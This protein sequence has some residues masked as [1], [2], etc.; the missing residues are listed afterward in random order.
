MTDMVDEAVGN[1]TRALADQVRAAHGGGGGGLL[2]CC[3]TNCKRIIIGLLMLSSLIKT[4]GGRVRR[5]AFFGEIER[6][7]CFF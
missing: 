7:A 3:P 1:V 2:N 5:G 4:K 6:A